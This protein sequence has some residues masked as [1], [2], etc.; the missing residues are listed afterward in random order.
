MRPLLPC[1][2]VLV[3]A[4]KTHFNG[5]CG[6]S[7]TKEAPEALSSSLLQNAARLGSLPSDIPASKRT[8]NSKVRFVFFAGLEGTGHHF[9]KGIL[10]RLP[11]IYVSAQTAELSKTLFNGPTGDGLFSSLDEYLRVQSGQ[12][13]VSLMA[14]MN[15]ELSITPGC[16]LIPL[17]LQHDADIGMMSYPN[18]EGVD[19]ATQNP[20]IF[21]LAKL[22]EAAGV[23]LRIVL[24]T[25]H[26]SD[27][28]QSEMKN[29]HE[30]NKVQAVRKI[31]TS[32]ALLSEQLNFLDPS[33]V[34]CWR[35]EEP[36]AKSLQLLSF[37]GL[38]EE[39][40]ENFQLLLK[41]NYNASSNGFP[42][43]SREL[44]VT[45]STAQE[46]HQRLMTKWC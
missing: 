31:S 35:Y 8:I 37:L 38:C 27:L 16:K 22:A 44:Q 11:S 43:L 21:E 6:E 23:D 9:W 46:M 28:V 5:S 3:V 30:I 1:L 33:F 26:P 7:Y 32:M 15:N 24:L 41:E 45:L 10:L 2:A 40:L 34:E 19:R 18:F 13:V 12:R 29:L 42:A 20:D 17:N 25:R 4:H 14:E 36:L 39:N